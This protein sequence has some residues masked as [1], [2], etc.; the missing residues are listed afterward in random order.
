M[1]DLILT[2]IPAFILLLVVEVLTLAAAHHDHHDDD[3]PVGYELKDT[4]TSL[5][6]GLGNVFINLGWKV[7]VAFIYA[8]AYEVTPL[9]VP[10]DAWWA[11]GLLFFADDFSYY[12]YHRAGHRVRM[13]WA[14]HVVHHSSEHYNLS[15]ALRQTWTPMTAL[16][17]WLWM[18]LLGFAPWM[19]LLAQSWN[20]LYQFW[21]HT[22]TIGR[23]P[24]WFEFVFNTPSH[25]RAHHGAN[26]QYLDKNYGG[27][28][29]LW[30]RLLGTFEP[31][32]ERVR[33]GLTTNV[34]TFHPLRVA[35]H[36]WIAL[37]RDMRSAKSW[38]DRI[39]YALRGPGWSPPSRHVVPAPDHAYLALEA[40]HGQ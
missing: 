14:S 34:G 13:F 1:V 32:V 2:A 19:V 7:V 39:G 4:R 16:P 30:D 15:T 8:G 10:S 26:E 33:Y 28:L 21:I 6:M 11:Y 17:F 40:Q 35:F 18:P 24:R 25:H 38:R 23:L 31:E 36:E 27:I 9:R 5:S 29:I 20:L 12:W 22:E 3:E 37:G